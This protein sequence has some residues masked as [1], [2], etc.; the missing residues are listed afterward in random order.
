MINIVPMQPQKLPGGVIDPN[1]IARR[2]QIAAALLDS[3]KPQQITHPM[4]GLAQLGDA[5]AGGLVDYRARKDQASNNAI[6]A[7][8]LG[9]MNSGQPLSQ[10]RLGQIMALNPE[11]GMQIIQQQKAE[12]RQAQQDAMPDWQFL[13]SGGDTYR[14]NSKDPDSKPEMFFD[15]P[16]PTPEVNIPSGYEPNP[17]APGAIM[18]MPGG[19]HDP[20]SA[21]PKPLSVTAQKELFEAEEAATAGDYVLSALDQAI[22]LNEFAW[23]GPM[24]AERAFGQSFIPDNIPL[25][26][27]N[28]G[29][30]QATLQLKNVTTELALTQLKTIFGAMPT[31]GERKILI[32]LQGSPS[33]PRNVRAEIYKR[34]KEMAIRRIE[35]SKRKAAAIRSGKFFEE[36]YSGTTMGAPPSGQTLTYN[37][38]TGELE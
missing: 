19:P 20:A 38:T 9:G 25:I 18:P 5:I 33:L 34:A 21:P 16:A 13:E 26:G 1:E 28:Q 12:A 17:D 37:P 8:A 3:A 27:G 14:F 11:L 35:D 31:E 7:E 2:E 22:A 36:G 15:G 29:Q 23:D 30:E 10:D 24:A 6:M 32:E 4:Q